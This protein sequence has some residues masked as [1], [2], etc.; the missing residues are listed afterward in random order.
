MCA[1]G[2][3]SAELGWARSAPGPEFSKKMLLRTANMY[4]CLPVL[5]GPSNVDLVKVSS[6][7]ATSVNG[8]SQG[9]DPLTLCTSV[10]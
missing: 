8:L 3:P 9:C 2:W 4:I 7:E 1:A 6:L 10:P 5:L